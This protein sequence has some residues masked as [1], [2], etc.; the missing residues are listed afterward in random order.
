[1]AEINPLDA[2]LGASVNVEKKVY[3]KRL[4]AYFTVKAL[5]GDKV[6]ELR[7]QCTYPVGKGAK[8]RMV[9]REEELG[10]LLIAEAC[11]KPDFKNAELHEKY[12]AHDAAS[13]VQKSLL[14]GEV[15]KLSNAVL[16]AS[17]FD[18]D[19]DDVEEVKN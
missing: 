16:D 8:Q 7:E 1:M 10:Q 19:D 3:I 17:G 12:G 18:Y 6:N 11:V 2:L 15:A 5:T 13:C 9:V 14:A 4:D